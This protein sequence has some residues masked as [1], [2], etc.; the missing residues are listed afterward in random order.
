MDTKKILDIV[1]LVLVIIGGLNWGLVA[2][3]NMDLVKLLFG[4]I[5]PLDTIV[6]VLVAL[7]ALYT[8]TIL[9][10]KTKK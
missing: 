4:G 5:P 9:L 7:S 10:E 6:Y 8:I 1:A 3:A 2:L